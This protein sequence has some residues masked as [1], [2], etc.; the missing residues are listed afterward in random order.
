MFRYRIDQTVETKGRYN[1][2]NKLARHHCRRH[3]RRKAT[4]TKKR[5]IKF[6]QLY[7]VALSR[8]LIKLSS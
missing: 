5:S 1:T 6:A 2:S 4:T 8:A 3:S 7:I